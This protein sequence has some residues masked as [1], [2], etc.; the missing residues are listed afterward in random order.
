MPD[1]D[2]PA[3]PPAQARY[4]GLQARRPG[5]LQSLDAAGIRDV[6]RQDP[7]SQAARQALQG[8]PALHPDHPGSSASDASD[9]ALPDHQGRS[10]RQGRPSEDVPRRDPQ[11][12]CLARSRVPYAGVQR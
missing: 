6:R 3:S 12:P 9:D 7:Q 10:V 1:A 11:N 5:V 8:H 4:L 2:H